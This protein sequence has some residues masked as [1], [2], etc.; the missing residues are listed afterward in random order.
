MPL[1]KGKSNK[2]RQKNIE[3]MI[4]AGHDVQ[5]SIAAAYSQ[6]RKAKGQPAKRKSK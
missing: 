2:T 6:Q 1:K 3:E 5:Q 4:H